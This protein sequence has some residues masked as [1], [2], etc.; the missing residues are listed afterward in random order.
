MGYGKKQIHELEQTIAASNAE[1]IIIGTPIDLTRLM[2]IKQ[3]SE[4]VR[5]ELEVIGQPGLDPI[6]IEKFPKS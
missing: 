6:L 3:P 1:L 4:R 2:K 5:Y